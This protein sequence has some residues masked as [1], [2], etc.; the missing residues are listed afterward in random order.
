M[1]GWFI[2][3]TCTNLAR[4]EFYEASRYGKSRYSE[5]GAPKGPNRSPGANGVDGFMM[6]IKERSFYLPADGI[7]YHAAGIELRRMYDIM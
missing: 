1:K 6:C 4:C 7:T 3:Q 5:S 2:N